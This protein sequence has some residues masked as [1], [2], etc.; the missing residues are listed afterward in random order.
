MQKLLNDKNKKPLPK[1][2][3]I[4]L[5]L[6]ISVVW[7]F[8]FLTV[9]YATGAGLGEWSLVGVR[10]LLAA[11]LIYAVRFCTTK[12]TGNKK[13]FRKNEVLWG[14]VVGAVNF[15]GFLFQTTSLTGAGK[16]D[17]ARCALFTSA[18]VVLVS[19]A[20]CV[21][22]K[23]FRIKAVLDALLFFGGMMIL[24]NP[25]TGN[26]LK[27][28]DFFA[29]LCSVF[30]AAQIL[31]VD[32]AKNT[33][34]L[35][36]NIVQMA[37]MGTMGV[38]GALFTDIRSVVALKDSLALVAVLYLALFSSAYAYIVQMLVQKRLSE[39]LSAILLSLEAMASVLFSLA[40]GYAKFSLPLLLGGG[41]MIIATLS[42]SLSEGKEEKEKVE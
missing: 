21:L 11:V 18:Y 29:I 2:I 17:T 38:I 32:K 39:S 40:F 37:T 6:S 22:R 19:I 30:F 36:F 26:P 10:F 1:A 20:S 42:A 16:T 5:A 33:D 41:V 9:D 3:Y 12:K 24:N 14:S 7:G 23:K 28:G 4:L 27:S 31:L 35:N 34:F 8:G 13:K 15:F 25:F